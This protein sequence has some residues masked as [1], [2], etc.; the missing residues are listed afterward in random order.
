MNE[1]ANDYKQLLTETLQKQMVILGPVI[2]LAKARHVA[3]LSVSDDGRVTAIEGNPQQV[4][5]NLLEQFREL[6]PLMVKKTMKPLLNTII[7]SYPTVPDAK[8]ADEEKKDEDKKENKPEEKKPFGLSPQSI[9]EAKDDEQKHEESKEEKP[10]SPAAQ[11]H[12]PVQP[13]PAAV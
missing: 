2:T 4:S 3:G 8:P 11:Q 1:T 5:I 9:N 7:A 10:E 6:S 13:G 12:I